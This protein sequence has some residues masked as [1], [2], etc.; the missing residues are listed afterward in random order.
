MSLVARRKLEE[1]AYFLLVLVFM[2]PILFVFFWMVSVSF[3]NNLEATAYPPLFIPRMPTLDG[4]RYVFTNPAQ[5]F[6]QFLWNSTVVAV[7]CTVLAMLLGVPAAFSI[8]RW[9]QNGLALGILLAR[10]TPGLSFLVPWFIMFRV[11]GLLDTYPALIISHL[12]VGLP[13]VVW[14][15]MGFF[16]DVPSELIDAGLIDGASIYGVLW[17][18]ALPLVQPGLVATAILSVIFSWNNFA[19][20]VV[21]AGPKTRTLPVAV[22][23]LMSFEQFNWGSLAAAACMITLPVVVMALVMQRHIVS[24]LT[25]GAVKQ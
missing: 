9:K 6:F 7:G 16:E 24:G 8:A 19:F 5:P 3:R 11:F 21:L 14:V 23:N 20:S 2:L 12:V 17:R 10:I 13:I 25:F 15:M 22:F 4:Y 18:I 1:V